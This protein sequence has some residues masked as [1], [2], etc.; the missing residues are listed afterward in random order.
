MPP[1]YLALGLGVVCIGTS[2]IFVKL[3]SVPGVVSAFY[4][5]FI[6][7]LA[8]LPLHLG[9]RTRPTPNRRS[10]GLVLLGSL[11][12]A[13]DLVLW[14]T[15]ILRTSAAAATLLAN[16]SPL[17][18]GLGAMLIFRERL[19]PVYWIGL[20]VALTG[21]AIIVGG[22]ALQELHFNSGDLLA[23]AASFFY[24]GYM[25]TTQKTRARIDTLTLNFLTMG[26]CSLM[27]LPTTLLFGQVL[28]GFSAGV[29]LSLLGL[30]LVPQFL[31]WLA[32][33]FALGQ[34]P[35]ARVSVTLLGQ[36]VV[37][38]IL[39]ILFLG[40]ALSAADLIGGLLVLLGIYLVNR[41]NRTS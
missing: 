39:G 5:V 13:G 28:T 8:L 2:A 14:N 20:L 32:I 3:A 23:V 38:A 35:A 24:A 34:L 30:G 21:M 19:S 9:A 18:V 33:N 31:G 12:F 25:L 37:T 16:N 36:S 41:R 4:R 10:W 17:W 1:A 11:F 29:W 40:E 7:L 26:A 22:N 15:S 6:A 27:L